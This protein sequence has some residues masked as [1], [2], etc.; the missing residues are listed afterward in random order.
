MKVFSRNEIGFHNRNLISVSFY[1]QKRFLNPVFV[2]E[3]TRIMFINKINII[4]LTNFTSLDNI[5]MVLRH[6]SCVISNGR[7]E[8]DQCQLS[9]RRG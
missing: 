5:N 8:K 2:Y 7:T 3:Y 4:G 1:E 9:V 6:G